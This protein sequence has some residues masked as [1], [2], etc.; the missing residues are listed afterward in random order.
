MMF[1][2]L[3][4]GV[5]VVI[6]LKVETFNFPTGHY[7]HWHDSKFKLKQFLFCSVC[8][9]MTVVWMFVESNGNIMV[10]DFSTYK[11]YKERYSLMSCD[12]LPQ[13]STFYYLDIIGG[14]ELL[15]PLRCCTAPK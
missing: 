8:L 10:P 6:I 15:K 2:N 3:C 9:V 1:M 14:V 7:C 12:K 11:E 13:P 5:C 4:V